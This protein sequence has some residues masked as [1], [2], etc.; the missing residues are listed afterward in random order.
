[1][2][3]TTEKYCRCYILSMFILLLVV[4]MWNTLW[5]PYFD[6]QHGLR[7]V[8]LLQLLYE[9]KGVVA[10]KRKLK[11]TQ[12]KNNTRPIMSFGFRN[13]YQIK[14]RQFFSLLHPPWIVAAKTTDLIQKLLQNFFAFLLLHSPQISWWQYIHL[15]S[16][17]RKVK[18]AFKDSRSSF[19]NFILH[20]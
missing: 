15:Q 4:F 12:T 7:K 20:S 5:I 17:G 3:D 18:P 14:E 13:N 2:I 11:K 9:A 16:K 10:L 1:M 6:I 8:H 19:N